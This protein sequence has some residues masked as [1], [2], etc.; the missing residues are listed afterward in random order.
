LRY[1]GDEIAGTIVEFFI[2]ILG[3]YF[4]TASAAEQASID[5]GGSGPG[6]IRTGYSFAWEGCRAPAAS[7]ARRA[8]VPTRISTPSILPSAQR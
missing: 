1:Q 2:T 4:I 3:H 5:A 6:W 7:T 8:W